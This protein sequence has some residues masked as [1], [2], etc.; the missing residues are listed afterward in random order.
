MLIPGRLTRSFRGLW[1]NEA[2]V[3]A[4]DGD[5][6]GMPLATL[7]LPRTAAYQ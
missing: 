4:R 7:R 5:P 2:G 6:G 3:Q 1:I